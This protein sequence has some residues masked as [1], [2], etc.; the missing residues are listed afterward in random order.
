MNTTLQ[1]LLAAMPMLM[2]ALVAALLAGQSSSTPQAHPLVLEPWVGCDSF[3]VYVHGQTIDLL[4]G[5]NTASAD[6]VKSC[7]FR[8][9]RSIDGGA[10]WSA[11]VLVSAG[12]RQ[13][14]PH[15]R[16]SDARLVA[17]GDQLFAAWT[18]PGTGFRGT[19]PMG[20]A[21]STDGGR[22]WQAGP[23]PSDQKTTGSSR[24]LALS[25]DDRA[26]HLVW[27]DDRNKQRGLRHASST[28]G[29]RTWSNNSTVDELTCACCW[30]TLLHLPSSKSKGHERGQLLALY[31]D[32]KPSDMGLARSVDGGKTW[33]KL[34]HVGSFEW[35]FD[36]CPH[37]GGGIGF[38]SSTD[39]DRQLFSV[40]WTGKPDR[41]GCH[42]LASED[43][44]RH[45]MPV[46]RIG[47]DT[48]KHPTL[49]TQGRQLCIA[50][51]DLAGEDRAVFVVLSSDE[52]ATWSKPMRLSSNSMQGSHV[53][54][55][56]A[57]ERDGF[58]AFWTEST[59]N[60]LP[61]LRHRLLSLASQP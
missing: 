27:L 25:A 5:T 53:R 38:T 8:H 41:V 50:Y 42:L 34:G 4:V 13:A 37:V 17:R 32:M 2:I 35:L 57:P 23:D 18:T 16:G 29:G 43:E 6:G 48:A 46:R 30:N 56:A 1:K 52:G 31:R 39:G 11:P 54:V 15:H 10:T 45:W 19:G 36:G 58:M 9:T 59:G 26:F 55:I 60:E 3:D 40:V 7:E 47:N 33:E 28:D 22:T 20:T 24:F 61:V 49:A 21:Y 12:S 14:V 44:G 51:D